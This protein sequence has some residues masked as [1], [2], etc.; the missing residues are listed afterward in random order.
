MGL[1]QRI[2]LGQSRTLS[3]IALFRRIATTG[4][5]LLC[6]FNRRVE[7]KAFPSRLLRAALPLL[8]GAP[9]N[10]PG[11]APGPPPARV[12]PYRTRPSPCP[13]RARSEPRDTCR[14]RLPRK[15]PQTAPALVASLRFRLQEQG[16]EGLRHPLPPR[17]R[18][19]RPCRLAAPPPCRSRP[20]Q[21]ERPGRLPPTAGS[22]AATAA[23]RP[24]VVVHASRRGC[25]QGHPVVSPSCP[26]RWRS[27]GSLRSL[28]GNPPLTAPRLRLGWGGS[29][30]LFH[31][32]AAGLRGRV[33]ADLSGRV[34]ER[35]ALRF[36]EA[37]LPIGW[38]RRAL[39]RSGESLPV[40]IL[41]PHDSAL[42]I[43]FGLLADQMA[44]AADRRIV[45]VG[46][47]L[48]AFRVG[49]RVLIL[50]GCPLVGC[51]RCRDGRE[52]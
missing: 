35:V 21:G 27:C 7:G 13:L 34:D 17:P 20:R 40:E 3:E 44:L 19:F 38:L 30:R 29:Y 4:S 46:G 52:Q 49:F 51:E 28:G 31:E 42:L 36:C 6:F 48:Y 5:R 11:S 43:V 1:S 8:R 9:R 12:A 23:Q 10:A 50:R 26:R 41:H 32:K 37:S 25:R 14:S 39:R 47:Y 33:E 18:R 24:P 2:G 45:R 22:V 16:R 15:V